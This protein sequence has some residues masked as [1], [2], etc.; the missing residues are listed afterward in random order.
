MCKDQGLN[1]IHVQLDSKMLVDILKKDIGF[2]WMV[3]KDIQELKTFYFY[4][5]SHCYRLANRVGNNHANL[6]ISFQC[7]KF[8]TTVVIFPKKF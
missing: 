4:Y 1:Q 8:F 6:S 3:T 5:L 7:N 2:S